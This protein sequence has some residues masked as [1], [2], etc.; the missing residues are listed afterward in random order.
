MFGYFFCLK[1]YLAE[2]KHSNHGSHA[3]LLLCQVASAVFTIDY[4]PTKGG[5]TERINPVTPIFSYGLKFHIP[6]SPV[7]EFFQNVTP[8]NSEGLL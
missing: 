3:E 2:N 7:I 5:T 6:V 8:A 4:L 1:T